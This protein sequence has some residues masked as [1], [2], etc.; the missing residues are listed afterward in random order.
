VPLILS[1]T[2]L[3]ESVGNDT[4]T[5]HENDHRRSLC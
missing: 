3:A 2:N 4:R 1:R 5:R